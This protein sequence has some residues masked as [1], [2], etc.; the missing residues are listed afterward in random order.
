MTDWLILCV[1]FFKLWFFF[2]TNGTF[3]ISLFSANNNTYKINEWDEKSH[4][5][6]FRAY[7]VFKLEAWLAYRRNQT[8]DIQTCG[9]LG[10][11]WLR[12][13]TSLSTIFQLYRAGQLNWWRKPKYPQKITD[14]SQVT[15][16]LR[17]IMDT[18]V[19]FLRWQVPDLKEL[20]TVKSTNDYE[21]SHLTLYF[22]NLGFLFCPGNVKKKPHVF[23]FPTLPAIRFTRR[24]TSPIL[25]RLGPLHITVKDV[26]LFT[27]TSSVTNQT[28][29]CGACSLRQSTPS[30]DGN[31]GVFAVMA[32]TRKH[33]IDRTFTYLNI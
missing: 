10:G 6:Y 17:F 15:D 1:V 26:F 5:R 29:N 7:S 4:I 9:L 3:L 24:D 19:D 23:I 21:Q 16:K 32:M 11:I 2:F 30:M 12:C 13:L 20:E 22:L 31:T 27:I 28:G 25:W 18:Q 14:L 8:T 33:R